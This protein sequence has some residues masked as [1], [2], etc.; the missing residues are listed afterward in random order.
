VFIDWDLK[1]H[2]YNKHDKTTSMNNNN[3]GTIAI[4][5]IS[6]GFKQYSTCKSCSFQ[7]RGMPMSFV[8]SLTPLTTFI[9]QLHYIPF[10]N[11]K[12]F[13]VG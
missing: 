1:K 2:G 8:L 12:R 3:K 4:A 6:K 7:N 9:S 11:L 10:G 13:S 5:D